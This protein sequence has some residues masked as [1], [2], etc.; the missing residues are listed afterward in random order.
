MFNGIP[1]LIHT[2][3]TVSGVDERPVII[4]SPEGERPI[5]KL[6]S[7]WAF[8]AEI[9][10][11]KEPRGLGDAMLCFRE[12]EYFDKTET[13]LAIW[14]DMI[15]VQIETLRK[16]MRLFKENNSVFAFPTRFSSPCYTHVTR[17]H[18][19]RVISLIERLEFGDAVPLI[20]ESDVGI[21]MFNKEIVFNAMKNKVGLLGKSTNEIGFL[22]V[23][24][25]LSE[26]YWI[27]AFQIA[28][29]I[30]SWSYNTEIDL[31]KAEEAL[32]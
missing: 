31:R 14:G 27:D 28:D 16:L 20:G 1:I 6:I 32:C 21:F 24:S 17:S 30:D 10:V 12:S 2:L 22:Q 29:E 8:K 26:Q 4:V 3:R 15:S 23:V 9:L 7:E 13:V 5:G 25:L 19:G 11:Q 18:E